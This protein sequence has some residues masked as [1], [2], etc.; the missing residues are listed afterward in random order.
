V[1]SPILE[2][3]RT[4][5]GHRRDVAR[6]FS[7]HQLMTH[8]GAVAFRVLVSLPPLLLLSLGLL[9]ALGLEDVWTDT[10]APGLA[11]RVTPPVYAAIDFSVGRI[12]GEAGGGLI[13]FAALLLLWEL[14]RGVRAIMV[15]LNVIHEAE[16]TRSP[17]RLLA[18]TLLLA[19]SVGLAIVLSA[20]IVVV[21]PRVVPGGLVE[22]LVKVAAWAAAAVLLGVAVALL[23]RYAPAEQP[24]PRWASAGSALIVVT[25]I[26][27]SLLFG[28]WAGSV[29][30]YKSAIGS[31]TV[32]LLLTAYV[33]VSSGILLVGAQLDELAR[34]Q[35][36][37]R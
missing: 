26:A 2:R 35:E 11:D 30:N 23:V 27:A 8:T 32:F 37:E 22:A 3:G 9:G 4:L 5:L 31:L 25:W 34:E 20:L 18:T 14:S 33:L 10:L 36:A 7:E 16:E 24:S 28:W 15:A 29:A 6:K 17:R 21:A 12:F 19:T 1:P 13:A